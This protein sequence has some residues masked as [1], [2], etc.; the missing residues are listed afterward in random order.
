MTLTRIIT[1][2]NSYWTLAMHFAPSRPFSW[3][4]SLNPHHIAAPQAA[5]NA[6]SDYAQPYGGFR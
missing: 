6:S 5:I 1:V 4:F 3:V 2:A